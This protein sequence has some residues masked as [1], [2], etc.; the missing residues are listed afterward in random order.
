MNKND[1]DAPDIVFPVPWQGALEAVEKLLID[2]LRDT[3]PAACCVPS[4][5]NTPQLAAGS[6]IFSEKISA[7]PTGIRLDR[8]KTG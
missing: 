8:P 5:V 6:F 3:Y 1:A 2:S 4:S 7:E